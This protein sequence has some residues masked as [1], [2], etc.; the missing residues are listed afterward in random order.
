MSF[1]SDGIFPIAMDILKSLVMAGAML[2]AVSL[3][4]KAV[5]LSGPP[6]LDE[7][8]DHRKF[9]TSSV[10]HSGCHQYYQLFQCM[11]PNRGAEVLNQ[12]NLL[13]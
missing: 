7:S 10:E 8:I 5:I 3:R 4:I 1:H 2:Q 11:S 12:F 6:A 13:I 9:K